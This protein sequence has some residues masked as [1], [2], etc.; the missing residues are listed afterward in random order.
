MKAKVFIKNAVSNIPYSIGHYFAHIPFSW[1]LGNAYTD[2][3]LLIEK[4]TSFHLVRQV[5]LGLL[6]LHVAVRR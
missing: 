6:V 1:R 2:S 5:S 4:Y 3:Q